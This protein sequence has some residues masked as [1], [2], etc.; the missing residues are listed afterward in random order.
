MRC[1]TSEDGDLLSQVD[2]IKEGETKDNNRS[3]PLKKMLTND[4][5]DAN[6][7]KIEG[8]PPLEYIFCFCR[9]YKKVTKNLGLHMTFKTA[10]IQD[11]IYTT[12][13]DAVQV[14]VTINSLYLYVPF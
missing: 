12:L 13:A 11:N 14:I 3:T 1:L 7:S 4:H 9:T 5:A 2:K 8:Q 10:N 6:K